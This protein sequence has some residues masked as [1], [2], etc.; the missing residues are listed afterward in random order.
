MQPRDH[1]RSRRSKPLADCPR[2]NGSLDVLQDP[3]GA[4]HGVVLDREC[5]GCE[6]RDSVVSSSLSV[7][8]WYRRETRILAELRPLVVFL[9]ESSSAENALVAKRLAEVN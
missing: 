9:V 1:E 6:Y 3:G 8:I 2:C 5:A 7:A 4:N